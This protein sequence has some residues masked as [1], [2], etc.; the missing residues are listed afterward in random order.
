MFIR[1]LEAAN[2]VLAACFLKA[3]KASQNSGAV[4][5]NV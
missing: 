5:R 3:P 2:L 4:R 1:T